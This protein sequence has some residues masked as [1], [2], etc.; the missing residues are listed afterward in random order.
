[1][2]TSSV[3]GGENTT[4]QIWGL[5]WCCRSSARCGEAP[6]RQKLSELWCPGSTAHS[7]EKPCS[8]LGPPCGEEIPDLGGRQ[9]P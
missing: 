7:W 8:A 6:A 5:H 1:M 3:A 2:E 4:A 9:W